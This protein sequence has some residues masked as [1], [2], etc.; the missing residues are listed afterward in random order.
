[1]KST[2]GVPILLDMAVRTASYM[3]EKKNK[4]L[5]EELESKKDIDNDEFYSLRNYKN[6]D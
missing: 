3:L 4:K 1:M 5:K 6:L 2:V